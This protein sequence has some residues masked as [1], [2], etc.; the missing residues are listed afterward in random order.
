MLRVIEELIRDC[1]MSMR[2]ERLSLITL[3]SK[4]L[5]GFSLNMELILTQVVLVIDTF[6]ILVKAHF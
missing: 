5:D 4:D 2:E 6:S 1:G 3:E